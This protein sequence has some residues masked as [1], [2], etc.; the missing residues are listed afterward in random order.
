MTSCRVQKR[1]RRPTDYDLPAAR[2]NFRTDSESL[3]RIEINLKKRAQLGASAFLQDGNRPADPL[4][5]T[6]T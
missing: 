4:T 2:R 3:A 6:T 1:F 5:A